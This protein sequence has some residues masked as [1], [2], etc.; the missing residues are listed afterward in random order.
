MPY[1]MVAVADFADLE[2]EAFAKSIVVCRVCE[3]L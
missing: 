1:D 3:Q 2:Y